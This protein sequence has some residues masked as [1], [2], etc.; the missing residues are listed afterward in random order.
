MGIRGVLI[1]FNSKL[2]QTG[3]Q[4]GMIWDTAGVSTAQFID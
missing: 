1:A 2:V 4:A 3:R